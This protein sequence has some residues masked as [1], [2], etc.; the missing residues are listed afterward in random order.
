[1][2]CGS[3]TRGHPQRPPHAQLR[4]SSPGSPRPGDTSNWADH[5]GR[6][7]VAGRSVGRPGAARPAGGVRRREVPPRRLRQG[8]RVGIAQSPRSVRRP[9]PS[10]GQTCRRRGYHGWLPTVRRLSGRFGT[11]RSCGARFSNSTRRDANPNL[12]IRR[13]PSGVRGRPQPSMEPVVSSSDVHGRPPPSAVVHR[14]WLPTW[15]SK[16]IV[17]SCH[18]R[19][20]ITRGFGHREAPLIAEGASQLG[21]IPSFSCVTFGGCPS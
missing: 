7:D 20:S 18:C 12:L 9:R 21:E 10:E 5:R 3:D 6:Q 14:Q 8:R 16:Q 11:E 15:L 19:Q 17:G 13:C 1:M 2:L 4:Q